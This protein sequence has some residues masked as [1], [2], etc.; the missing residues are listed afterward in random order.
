[1]SSEVLQQPTLVLNRN[2]QAVNVASVQ[3]AL[4]MVCQ[5]RARVVDPRDFQLYSWDAWADLPLHSDRY[6]QSVARPLQAPEIVS[7]VSYDRVPRGTVRFSKRN[8]FKRDRFVC[9]YCN[10]QPRAQELTLDHVMP[11]ARAGPTAWDNCVTACVDCNHRKAD[12]TPQEAGM[13]LRSLPRRPTWQ[14][15]YTRIGIRHESWSAF[16]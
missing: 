4:R 8:V 3:K 16:F 6:I 12:R 5:G 13:R 14:P 15:L 9:Q 2:W 1:M 11:R 7:L 10:C